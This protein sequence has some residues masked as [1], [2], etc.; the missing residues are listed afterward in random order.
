[1]GYIYRVGFTDVDCAQRLF[2]GSYYTWVE[3]AFETW[4]DDAG[5]PWKR[6]FDEFDLGLPATETRCHYLSSLAFEDS[7]AVE[8]GL[9]ELDN[10]GFVLDFQFCR[11][12]DDQLC[13]FGYSRRRFVA[14]ST[15]RP[16][17]A[18]P[19]VPCRVFTD[20]A[21]RRIIPTYEERV[22]QHRAQRQM[23]KGR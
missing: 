10:R 4:Q 3:R 23:T 11:L 18:P 7:F 9:R 15:G 22:A 12:N 19:E 16:V 14:L 20:M 8:L 1:M 5:L 13:A 2:S 6:L 21:A 17:S